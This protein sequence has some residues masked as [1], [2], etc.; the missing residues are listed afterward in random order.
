MAL[1]V[2]NT[3]TPLLLNKL[4]HAFPHFSKPLTKLTV[5]S[6]WFGNGPNSKMK[7]LLTF[8]FL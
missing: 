1:W 7:L 3:G 4:K 6:H 2:W 8:T 5:P